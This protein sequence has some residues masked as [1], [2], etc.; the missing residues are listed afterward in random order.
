[1]VDNRCVMLRSPLTP[2]RTDELGFRIL[3]GTANDLLVQRSPFDV[4]IRCILSSDLIL[5]FVLVTRENDH[6]A[7]QFA[8][9]NSFL[10]VEFMREVTEHR[11]KMYKNS[12]V[13]INE[14]SGRRL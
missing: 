7:S 9:H 6:W 13:N 4:R 5:A 1:M 12:Q 10:D 3:T 11:I 8:R 2:P 14:C